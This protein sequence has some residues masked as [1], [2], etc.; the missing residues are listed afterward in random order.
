VDILLLEKLRQPFDDNDFVG[1][2]PEAIRAESTNPEFSL[3]DNNILKPLP[4]RGT[5]VIASAARLEDGGFE[6]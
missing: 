5:L 1:K 2:T 6:G 4:W 3:S